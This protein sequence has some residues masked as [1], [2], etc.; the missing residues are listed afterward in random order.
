[1]TSNNSNFLPFEPPPVPDGSPYVLFQGDVMTLVARRQTERMRTAGIDAYWENHNSGIS[2]SAEFKSEWL[3]NVFVAQPHLLCAMILW[4]L[5]FRGVKGWQKMSSE[6]RSRIAVKALV[7]AML[8]HGGGWD[9][10]FFTPTGLNWLQAQ[11]SLGEEGFQRVLGQ[12]RRDFIGIGKRDLRWGLW[13]SAGCFIVGGAWWVILSFTWQVLVL[14]VLGIVFG[15]HT[16]AVSRPRSRQAGNSGFGS[17]HPS[18]EKI[19]AHLQRIQQGASAKSEQKSDKVWVG[20]P[21]LDMGR[22]LQ[23][24]RAFLNQ[25]DAESA[26][27][28]LESFAADDYRGVHTAYP[29]FYEILRVCQQSL[30]KDTRNADSQIEEMK[31]DWMTALNKGQQLLKAGKAQESIAY[32]NRSLMDNPGEYGTSSAVSAAEEGIK[33]AKV[34]LRRRQRSSQ[35]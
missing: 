3:C 19:Q 30:G 31:L 14:L 23:Q 25:N 24:A 18:L 11:L 12:A 32:F 1:M 6:K 10:A 29:E 26:L 35:S 28:V 17:S 4:R 7:D 22:S 15:V 33:A 5:S 21:Y 13:L 34:L 27:N 16:L 20:Q 9:Q 8:L 2:F